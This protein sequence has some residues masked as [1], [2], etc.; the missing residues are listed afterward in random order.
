LVCVFAGID[1]VGVKV[2][3]VTEYNLTAD[4]FGEAWEDLGGSV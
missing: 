3:G 4:L 2:I 1:V